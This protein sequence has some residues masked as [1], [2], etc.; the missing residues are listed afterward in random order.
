MLGASWEGRKWNDTRQRRLEERLPEIVAGAMQVADARRERQERQQKEAEERRAKE[1][2][3]EDAFARRAQERKEYFGLRRES[4]RW[5]LACQIRDYV[6]AAEQA[7][8]TSGLLTKER[9]EWLAWAR[10]KADW[11]DPMVEVCDIVLDAPMP[12]QWWWR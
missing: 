8:E 11:L 5:R 6:A 4:S 9:Q 2:A 1:E 12:Q 10:A 7:A 3:Y